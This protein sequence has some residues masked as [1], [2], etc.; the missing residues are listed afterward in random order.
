MSAAGGG[1]RNKQASELGQEGLGGGEWVGDRTRKLIQICAGR[2]T[3]THLL[4]CVTKEIL[5]SIQ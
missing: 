4:E 2:D 1:F 5:K 3:E